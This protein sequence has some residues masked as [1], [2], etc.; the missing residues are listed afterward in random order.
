MGYVW[1]YFLFIRLFSF[2][3]TLCK[4]TR[5]NYFFGCFK[6]SFEESSMAVA[7]AGINEISNAGIRVT[8]PARSMNTELVSA[9]HL[10]GMLTI[11]RTIVDS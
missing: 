4:K 2:F 9:I 8:D 6:K 10:E 1:K 7:M 5:L 11:A 3:N